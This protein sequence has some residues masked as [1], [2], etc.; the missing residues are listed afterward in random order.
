MAAVRCNFTSL[1]THACPLSQH[2]LRRVIYGGPDVKRNFL[3]GDSY[4]PEFTAAARVLMPADN[5]RAGDQRRSGGVALESER[6]NALD[7]Q[8]GRERGTQ[9]ATSRQRLSRTVPLADAN[10]LAE[11]GH[12][13]TATIP[14][15]WRVI[16]GE[17]K[18]RRDAEDG[19]VTVSLSPMSTG[20]GTSE[21]ERASLS[22]TA[23]CII[24]VT[25]RLQAET[26]L[27]YD[28]KAL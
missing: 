15:G 5:L 27:S 22:H 10:G 17:G 13:G 20:A 1:I 18:R 21:R 16:A 2:P 9:P 23:A 25:T 4:A 3:L 12:I 28:L 19:G 26:F 24:T 11:H 7:D 8:R 6:T 14:A